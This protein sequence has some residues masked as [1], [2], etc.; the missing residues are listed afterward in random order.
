MKTIHDSLHGEIRISDT[1]IKIIDSYLYER[2]NSIKQTSMAYRV[3]PAATHTRKNHQIG[4]YGLTAR[5][6]DQLISRKQLVI[7]DDDVVLSP[8]QM[9]QYMLSGKTPVITQDEYE[10]ICIGGLVHDLGHGPASHSFDDLLEEFIDEGSLPKDSPWAT[11]EQRSQHFFRYLVKSSPDIN[12]SDEAVHYICQIIEPTEEYVNDFRFQF[13]NNKVNGIDIDK[14]D[15]IARD[16]YVFGLHASIDI[17]RL[18]N[19]CNVSVDTI[20]VNTNNINN[21]TNVTTYNKLP[22]KTNDKPNNHD[23]SDT[24]NGTFWSFNERIR[25]D[26]FNLFMVRFR[27]YKEIYNHPKVIKFE[28]AYNDLLKEQRQNILKTMENQDIDTFATYTDESIL[29]QASPK[30]RKDFFDRSTYKLIKEPE[31]GAIRIDR[32]VGFF[33]KKGFNPFEYIRFYERKSGKLIQLEPHD[34]NIFLTFNCTCERMTYH[35]TNE[36]YNDSPVNSIITDATNNV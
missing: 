6:L 4:V 3:F 22:D 33:G 5:T 32:V 18:I 8:K 2:L 14:I 11:H 13:I 1:A 15:Y 36:N 20:E 16:N 21:M 26:I 30:L 17:D 31:P 27:L 29:W 24:R 23:N 34:I 35:Y 25:N 9:T 19:N 10:W 12:L 7:S 28:L